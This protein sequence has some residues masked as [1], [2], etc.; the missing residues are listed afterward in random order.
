MTAATEIRATTADYIR[1]ECAR[2][3]DALVAEGTIKAWVAT[4]MGH[5]GHIVEVTYMTGDRERV[6]RA[7]AAG[8]HDYGFGWLED[9]APEDF[10]PQVDYSDLPE[11]VRGWLDGLTHEPKRRWAADYCRAVL[12]GAP[13]P[14]ITPGHYTEKAKRRAD[15][16]FFSG[17]GDMTGSLR[18]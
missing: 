5:G 15:R 7:T 13:E 4:D 2:R 11:C 16:L 14:E 8:V 12:T 17:E 3:L 10:V 6:S 18:R 9:F 1:R